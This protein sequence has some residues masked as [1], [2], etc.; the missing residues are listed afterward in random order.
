MGAP[1]FFKS[2]KQLKTDLPPHTDTVEFSI[3]Q[4]SADIDA[5]IKLA[6]CSA[7]LKPKIIATIK[8]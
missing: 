8:K 6:G 4:D 5:S 3:H 1:G 7:V 2:L